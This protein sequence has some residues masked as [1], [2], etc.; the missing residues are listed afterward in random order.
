ME[1]IKHFRQHV[2]TGDIYAI[3]Q[4]LDGRLVGCCGPLVEDNLKDLDSY[5]YSNE[6]N[7]L[8]QEHLDR[9]ILWFPDNVCR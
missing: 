1:T 2:E 8:V 9:L 3:E 5:D 6:Q 7:D 4:W